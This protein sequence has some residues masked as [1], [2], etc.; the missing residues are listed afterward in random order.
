MNILQHSLAKFA[1]ETHS[2]R[3]VMDRRVQAVLQVG[4][5]FT[6]LK[7]ASSSEIE[8]R[9]LVVMYCDIIPK[10]APIIVLLHVDEWS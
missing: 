1:I 10:T 5:V 6:L 3:C 8:Q 9:L 4:R 2:I 7:H